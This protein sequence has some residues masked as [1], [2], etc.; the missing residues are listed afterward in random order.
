MTTTYAFE[1]LHQPEGWLSPGYVTVENGLITAVEASAPLKGATLPVA[2]YAL[3]GMHNLHS[4]AFQRVLAGRTESVTEMRTTDDLWTWREAMYGLVEA[5]SPADYQ[6]IAEFVYVHLLKGGYTTV[7]EFHYL[8]HAPGGARYANPAETSE[9]LLQAAID[10]GIALTLL[11]TLYLHGGIGRPVAGPQRRFA[12][13]DPSEYLALIERLHG[14]YGATPTLRIG[15]ALH[16]LRAVA[17]AELL[18]VTTAGLQPPERRVHIHVSETKQEVAEVEAGLGARPVRWLLDHTDLDQRWTLVHA[19]H[20][21][22]AEQRGL[23]TS[24][25]VVGLCPLTEAT[26]GDGVF[27]LVEHQTAGGAWGIGSDSNY[28]PG[29]AEEL[30]MLECGQRLRLARRNILAVPGSAVTAHSGRRLY[31]LALAGGSQASGGLSASLTKGQR[32]DIVVLDALSPGLLGHGPTTV[33]DAWL[34]GGGEQAVRDVMV[35]GRWIIRDRLHPREALVARR[36]AETLARLSA[37]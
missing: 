12:H 19:T 9:R 2:G 22:A 25:A 24:G 18:A 32:A 8:H 26:L 35:N 20:L 6:A 34:L 1:H 15:L 28:A 33:L 4:H 5:L 36:Y 14:A 17:P 30:R 11:P 16:S 7:C 37:H 29:V 10:S 27:P 31:D 3:P 13:E 23:A 21:D